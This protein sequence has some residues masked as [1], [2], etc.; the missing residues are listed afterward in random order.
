MRGGETLTSPI[1]CMRAG[2]SAS[3]V[4]EDERDDSALQLTLHV[5][6]QESGR[7]ELRVALDGSLRAGGATS[8]LNVSLSGPPGQPMSVRVNSAPDTELQIVPTHGCS[9]RPA[10][11]PPPPPV[12]PP[13]PVAPPAPPPPV[14]PPP[15]PSPPPPPAPARPANTVPSVMPVQPAA[16]AP[17]PAVRPVAAVAQASAARPVSPATAV[18]AATPA[19]AAQPVPE[20]SSEEQR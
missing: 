10:P 14:A 18:P 2:G 17:I 13:S 15:P 19:P 4:Q 6:M 20:R 5:R 9:A 1:V 3:I 12:P 7:N 16:R 8:R 11:P